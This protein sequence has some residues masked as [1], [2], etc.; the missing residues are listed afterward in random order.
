MSADGGETLG[1]VGVFGAV[2]VVGVRGSGSP[3]SI[4]FC[5]YIYR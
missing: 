3:F 1:D 4:A 5:R 2:G